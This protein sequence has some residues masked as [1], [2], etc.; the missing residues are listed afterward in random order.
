MRNIGSK[1]KRKRYSSTPQMQKRAA[2]LSVLIEKFTEQAW[3]QR[4]F[5]K[6]TDFNKLHE[7]RD[8]LVQ[9]SELK[10]EG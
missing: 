7:V 8:H 10:I 6:L 4:D 1:D 5:N 9:L 2:R 3:A